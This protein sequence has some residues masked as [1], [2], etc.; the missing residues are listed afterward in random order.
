MFERRT[1]TDG[2]VCRIAASFNKRVQGTANSVA[3]FARQCPAHNL[4]AF[5]GSLPRMF[6][7][8]EP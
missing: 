3:V 8:P 2:F 1:E 6:A 7:A 5:P 4:A